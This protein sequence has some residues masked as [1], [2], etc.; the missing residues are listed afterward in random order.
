MK[1]SVS[2]VVVNFNGSS[3]LQD[4]LNSLC[5]QSDSQVILVDNGSSIPYEPF[6]P[7]ELKGRLKV[8]R[9]ERNLGFAEAASQGLRLAQGE[10]R[11]LLNNDVVLASDFVEKLQDSIRKYPQYLIFAPLVL[12]RDFPEYVDSAGLGIFLDGVCRCRGWQEKRQLYQKPVEVLGAVGSVAVFHQSV[13]EKVGYFDSD[14]F[15]YLE[16]LDFSLRSQWLGLK[17]LYAPE[18]VAWH[19][20]SS[21]VGKHTPEKAYHVERNH[22]WVAVKNFPTAFLFLAPFFTLWRY[23]LQ[24]WAALSY[25]GIT[26]NFIR[27]YSRMALVGILFRAYRDAFCGLAKMVAKRRDI[28]RD[29]RRISSWQFFKILWRHQLRWRDFALKD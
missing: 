28:F 22:V 20:R 7:S 6:V 8:T 3:L 17:C 23:L 25:R 1:F 9:N 24:G 4:C 2:F 11:V 15:L 27:S 29:Q 19:V 21:T 14:F 13:L 18:L 5:P 12:I 16:D 26:G 10:W